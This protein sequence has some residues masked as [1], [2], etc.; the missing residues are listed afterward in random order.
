MNALQQTCKAN[1][2]DQAERVFEMSMLFGDI[3]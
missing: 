3:F 1:E 2:F